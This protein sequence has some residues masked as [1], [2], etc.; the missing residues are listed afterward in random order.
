MTGT[1]AYVNNGALSYN[2]LLRALLVAL[3]A[4][5]DKG[6]APPPSR[7]P[8]LA[9]GTLVSVSEA[10]KGFPAIPGVRFPT[11]VNEVMSLDYGPKFGPT[12]GYLTRLPPSHGSKY[13]LYVPRTDKEGVDLGG[14]R[15]LDIAMGQT[16]KAFAG[17][18]ECANS[19]RL[20]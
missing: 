16:W 20:I 11:V 18:I 9:D 13:Q 17:S 19:A 15:T 10:A 1:C 14:I 12:G 8:S 7:Y 2:A 5:A 6:M 4:W 3:D